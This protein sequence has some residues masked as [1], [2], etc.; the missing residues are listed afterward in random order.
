[1]SDYQILNNER[2]V[3]KYKGNVDFR[4]LKGLSNCDELY[5]TDKNITY[6]K[7]STFGNSIKDVFRI[8]INMIS[9]HDD[10]PD[11]HL[12]KS[13]RGLLALSIGL[14]NGE[15]HEIEFLNT[16]TKKEP[17][18]FLNS[19]FNM[20]VGHDSSEKSMLD[21][22]SETAKS[23]T[24]LGAG[25]LGGTAGEMVHSFKNKLNEEGNNYI[26]PEKV[27]SKCSGCGAPITGTKGNVVKCKYCDTR[28]VL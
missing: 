24:S 14:K 15:H 25:L 5:L 27:S 8:P 13:R 3:L 12:V 28:N 2:L 19:L 21:G 4:E 11:L 18:K 9:V 1:M 22:F 6:V 16:L 20:L 10:E 23:I 7:Y 26:E 17:I